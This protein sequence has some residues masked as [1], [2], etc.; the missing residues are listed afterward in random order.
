MRFFSGAV[1]SIP[2]GNSAGTTRNTASGR[3]PFILSCQRTGLFS[4][5][6]VRFMALNTSVAVTFFNCNLT[7]TES[8]LNVVPLRKVPGSATCLE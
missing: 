4:D 5:S 6:N 2:C 8:G 1:E 3:L 7:L